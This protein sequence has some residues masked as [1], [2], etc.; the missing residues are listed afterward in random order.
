MN[1][2]NISKLI[3]SRWAILALFTV[4]LP[5]SLDLADRLGRAGFVND[6]PSA[7]AWFI[8]GTVG[9]WGVTRPLAGE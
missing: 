4:S 8:S 6:I 3:R 5:V 2:R 7:I 1:Y 9:L